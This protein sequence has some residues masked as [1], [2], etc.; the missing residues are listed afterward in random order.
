MPLYP[1]M[2]KYWPWEEKVVCDNSNSLF[3]FKV[4]LSLFILL[5][6]INTGYKIQFRVAGCANVGLIQIQYQLRPIS[7]PLFLKFCFMHLTSYNLKWTD[8]NDWNIVQEFKK[9]M[10]FSRKTY[11]NMKTC[12][13][14]KKHQKKTWKHD[15][16]HGCINPIKIL[17]R[18]HPLYQWLQIFRNILSQEVHWIAL[19][20]VRENYLGSFHSSFWKIY[21]MVC[22]ILCLHNQ[23][24]LQMLCTLY[25]VMDSFIIWTMTLLHL[26]ILLSMISL[27]SSFEFKITAKC[28]WLAAN[29]AFVNMNGKQFFFM[30][31]GEAY[32]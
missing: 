2:K 28:F 4:S 29:W 27:K 25:S 10:N 26:Q 15:K 31:V 8:K 22:H 16:L 1:P 30:L 9:N 18:P 17:S 20:T 32:I 21:L 3:F 11:K 19:F 14:H 6:Y 12:K 7:L 23:V 5:D 13:T 24:V